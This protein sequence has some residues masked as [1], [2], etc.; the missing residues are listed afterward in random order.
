MSMRI[1]RRIRNDGVV[2]AVRRWPMLLPLTIVV[3]LTTLE[4]VTWES[5]STMVEQDKDV[6]TPQILYYTT[7]IVVTTNVGRNMN[8]KIDRDMDTPAHRHIEDGMMI[9]M[10]MMMRTL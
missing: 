8:V 1:G 7:I 4:R 5:K 2:N 6:S 10:H 3:I 9:V